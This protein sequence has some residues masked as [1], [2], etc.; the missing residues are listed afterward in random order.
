MAVSA[1]RLENSFERYI[2]EVRSIWGDCKNPE[3]PFKV[4]AL[5]ENMLA[6]TT[7]D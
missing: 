5:M 7:R 1:Q 4:K 3:L 2:A 6:A